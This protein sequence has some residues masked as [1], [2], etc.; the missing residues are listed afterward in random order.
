CTRRPAAASP[1]PTWAR[2]GTS[3]PG[4]PWSSPP[5]R[6]GATSPRPTRDRSRTCTTP[7]YARVSCAWASWTRSPRRPRA[8]SRSTRQRWPRTSGSWTSH[9]ASGRWPGYGS[10]RGAPPSWAW[11]R[12]CPRAVRCSPRSEPPRSELRPE[13]KSDGLLVAGQELPRDLLAQ[14][15][16]VLRA[17]L[18]RVTGQHGENPVG[19]DGQ[20]VEVPHAV[21]VQQR[22]AVLDRGFLGQV[23]RE[24]VDDAPPAA[25][26]LLGHAASDLLHL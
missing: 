23:R 21:V 10:S 17:E 6:C 24:G 15:G 22:P 20:A 14:C 5:G 12:P 7:S 25:V 8:G 4:C 11:Y 1:S 18:A 13:P 3:G 19:V 2:R 26:R 16:A 9:W